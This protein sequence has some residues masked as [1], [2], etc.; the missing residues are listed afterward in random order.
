M[1]GY[2][3]SILKENS[4][5]F[6]FFLVLFFNFEPFAQRLFSKEFVCLVKA[7]I[8][9]LLPHFA[10]GYSYFPELSTLTLVYA[11]LAKRD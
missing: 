2:L 6:Y 7:N 10:T 8:R 1:K 4:F 3:L 11:P 9:L 5:Y